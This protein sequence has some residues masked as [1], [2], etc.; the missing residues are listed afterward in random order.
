MTEEATIVV[1]TNVLLNLATPVVDGREHAP[2]GEDPLVA[3]LS[4][5]DVHVPA[6]VLGEVSAAAT[7]NDLLA[8]A[9]TAVLR[10][11]HHLKTH[12][13]DEES[14]AQLGYGLDTGEA[15]GIWLANELETMMFVTDEF[16]TTNYLLVSLALDDRNTLFTTP[17]LLCV[18]ASNHVLSPEYVAEALSYY[19]ETK[20]WEKQYIEQLRD[21]YLTE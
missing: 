20:G 13:V 8:A 16:N 6:S 5:Y 7:G 11:S 1:D 14:N 10:A 4:T 2:R 3:V 15:Q 17:H 12:D 19:V 21:Q 9:A 18:L